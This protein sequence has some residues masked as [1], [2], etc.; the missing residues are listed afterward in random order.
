MDNLLIRFFCTIISEHVESMTKTG[1]E[2]T[3]LSQKRS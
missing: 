1:T 3:K 2:L